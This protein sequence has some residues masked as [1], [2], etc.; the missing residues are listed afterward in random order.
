MHSSQSC[1]TCEGCIW[2]DQCGADEI[3]DDYSPVDDGEVDTYSHDLLVRR[4]AYREIMDEY[5]DET[6]LSD[7]VM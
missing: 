3:C 6:P 4:D 1:K 5:S 2:Y 7:T